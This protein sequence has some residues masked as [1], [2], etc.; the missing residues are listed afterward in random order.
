MAS[1][2][3]LSALLCLSLLAGCAHKA[4]DAAP[5]G[6]TALQAAGATAGGSTASWAAH[7]EVALAPGQV[8][9]A[10]RFVYTGPLALG[11][12]VT[13]TF[14]PQ[15][16]CPVGICV[17]SS[18]QMATVD[19]SDTLPVGMPL[20]VTATLSTPAL[21]TSPALFAVAPPEDRLDE[22]LTQSGSE[23]TDILDLQRNVDGPVALRLFHGDPGD[24][25]LAYTLT[26]AV[27]VR[28]TLL[29]AR[30]PLAIQVPQ[31]A[32]AIAVEAATPGGDV[33]AW[34]AKDAYLGNRS[35]AS[36]VAVL[37]VRQA[38]EHV[39]QFSH[40]TA[41][42]HVY[43][44]APNG[45]APPTLRP[46]AFKRVAGPTHDGAGATPVEWSFPVDAVPLGVGIAMSSADPSPLLAHVDAD[47]VLKGPDGSEL[48]LLHSQLCVCSVDYALGSWGMETPAG[49][50][51]VSYASE[52]SAQVQLWHFVD[53]Y[54]R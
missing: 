45:T 19:I 15:Q 26:L 25:S 20:H 54:V 48:D 42:L 7:P 34:D 53:T 6:G 52:A 40:A 17:S 12:T 18:E 39:L 21:V 4:P 32:T 14:A 30:T 51:S 2:R 36:G 10:A 22:S 23:A 1:V 46:L 13:G 38:G 37:P 24:G 50:Y 11:K 31:G 29:D 35:L 41:A 16:V 9:I 33:R 28:T 47:Y 43:V 27:E 8:P 49:T 3:F 44:L 5:D